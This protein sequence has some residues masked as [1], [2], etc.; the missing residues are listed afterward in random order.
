MALSA[1][2]KSIIGKTY[3]LHYGSE[4]IPFLDTLPTLMDQDTAW[5][6]K[7]Q[8]PKDASDDSS[9][10]DAPIGTP[11]PPVSRMT[12]QSLADTDRPVEPAQVPGPLHT[13]RQRKASL[14]LSTKLSMMASPTHIG[15]L[16]DHP[17]KN[18]LKQLVQIA[19]HLAQIDPES[20]AYEITRIECMYFLEIQVCCSTAF[21]PS[22][23][24]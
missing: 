5:A 8:E 21:S 7:V 3:L 14:P 19:Q 24:Y 13:K 16:D 1:L 4:F 6:M 22:L 17:T 2:I 12:S 20:I 10:A 11:A 15:Y 18:Q 23:D 9:L